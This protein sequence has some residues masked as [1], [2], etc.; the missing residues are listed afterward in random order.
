MGSS[1]FHLT[2]SFLFDFWA[3]DF[4]LI[5][6]ESY[7]FWFLMFL[8]EV[9]RTWTEKQCKTNSLKNKTLRYFWMVHQRPRKRSS[10]KSFSSKIF[11]SKAAILVRRKKTRIKKLT[12]KWKHFMMR[13]SEILSLRFQKKV[14]QQNLKNLYIFFAIFLF[15]DDDHRFF[16]AEV[17]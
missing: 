13:F 3:N 9:S 2:R 15:E 11:V 17:T 8:D 12:W 1:S 14:V 7:E 10:Y 16:S 5:K 6:S 4:I